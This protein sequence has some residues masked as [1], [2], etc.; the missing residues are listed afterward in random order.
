MSAK[1]HK[2]PLQTLQISLQ[3]NDPEM[4]RCEA[5]RE[6]GV[7]VPRGTQGVRKVQRPEP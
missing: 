2:E 6:V 7:L 3:V 5:R 4:L 1:R